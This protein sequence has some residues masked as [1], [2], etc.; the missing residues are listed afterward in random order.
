MMMGDQGENEC[1]ECV[2]NRKIRECRENR[3]IIECRK[4]IENRE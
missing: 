1:R 2:E 3:E 4:C